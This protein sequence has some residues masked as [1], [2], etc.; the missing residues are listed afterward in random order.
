MRGDFDEARE[1]MGEDAPED[2]ARRLAGLATGD[3]FPLAAAESCT[4]G[5]AAA[6]LT[7]G[8]GAS[9]WFGFGVVCYSNAAKTGLLGVSPELLAAHGAVSEEVA[10]AMCAGLLARGAGC[11]FS[12]TGIAGPDGGSAAKPRGTVC[13]GWG[14]R[15]VEVRTTTRLFAGD[16]EAVR[17]GAAVFVLRRTA[18]ALERAREAGGFC[19]GGRVGI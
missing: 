2:L 12:V 5:L 16:R 7:A 4:G 11:G 17:R 8:A 13:F 15:G 19:G 6:M 10:A 9:R 14:A 18:E 1:A 3:W